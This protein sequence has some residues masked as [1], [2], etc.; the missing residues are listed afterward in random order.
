MSKYVSDC[1]L[2]SY[3]KPYP[4]IH[5]QAGPNFLSKIYLIAFVAN[6]GILGAVA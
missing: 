3:A 2:I 4:I 6:S 5:C 1:T